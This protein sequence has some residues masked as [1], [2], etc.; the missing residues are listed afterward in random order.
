MERRYTAVALAY[1]KHNLYEKWCDRNFLSWARPG[2]RITL[3]PDEFIMRVHNI[4]KAVRSTKCELILL[5]EEEE[6]NDDY[7][8]EIKS[9]SE[10]DHWLSDKQVPV[11]LELAAK[12]HD[13]VDVRNYQWYQMPNTKRLYECMRE[14]FANLIE[15]VEEELLIHCC[16]NSRIRRMLVLDDERLDFLDQHD[17]QVQ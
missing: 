16:I 4:E 3:E 17:I 12:V 10:Y 2:G 11:C 14:R 15:V 6:N 5:H 7:Q 1:E 8:M 13:L 9:L